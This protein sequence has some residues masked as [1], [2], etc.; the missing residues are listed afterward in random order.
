MASS[1]S[2][3]EKNATGLAAT[4]M[5]R[6]AH[7]RFYLKGTAAIRILPN[8]PEVLGAVLNMSDGGCGIEMG[9]AIPA[10]VGARVEL[11][12]HVCGATMKRLGVIRRIDVIR[13]LEKETQVGIEFIEANGRR[14]IQVGS[15]GKKP[16]W[17]FF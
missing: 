12:L 13:R 3:S 15:L 7:P 2:E 17:R 1:Q 4:P 14:P 11:D 9:I 16:F 10:Q 6:R 8:G 5:E